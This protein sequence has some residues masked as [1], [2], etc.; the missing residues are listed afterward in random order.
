MTWCLMRSLFSYVSFFVTSH[1]SLNAFNIFPFIFGFIQFEFNIARGSRCLSV[2][3]SSS[4]IYSAWCSQSFHGSIFWCLPFI[5]KNSQPLLLHVFLL[6]I[7]SVFSF[8]DFNYVYISSFDLVTW[9][10]HISF[11]V[12]LSIYLSNLIYLI[13]SWF[14]CG[15]VY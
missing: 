8:C 13:S 10:F 6:P 4:L 1:F 14:S 15:N 5:F 12:L 3:L 7:F 11:C 2:C 9:F